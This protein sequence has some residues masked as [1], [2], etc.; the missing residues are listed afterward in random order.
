MCVCIYIYKILDG[1]LRVALKRH[2]MDQLGALQPLGS[3]FLPR[4]WTLM[5]DIDQVNN[6]TAEKEET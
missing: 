2:V 4:K 3:S 1:V 5:K 6:T